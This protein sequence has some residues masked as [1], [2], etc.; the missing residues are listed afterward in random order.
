MDKALDQ[1]AYVCSDLL[2]P[3]A[4]QYGFNIALEELNFGEC[5]ILNSSKETFDLAQK[6]NLPRINIVCDIYHIEKVGEP[7]ENL[8][9]YGSRITHLHF[10]RPDSRVY[11]SL[12]DG[13]KA[14][15][16]TFFANVRAAG[17][18]GRISLESKTLGNFEAELAASAQVLNA[19]L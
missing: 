8:A 9:T 19:Y 5:N 1:I 2:N 13:A 18:D 4:E 10:A 15:Y 6:L 17:Y 11:P 14:D 3:L 12:D 16:D 7:Y